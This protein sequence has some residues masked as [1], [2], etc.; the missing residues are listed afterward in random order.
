[1][2]T[3]RATVGLRARVTNIDRITMRPLL[4]SGLGLVV[5]H[6]TGVKV[7]YQGKS[8]A[9]LYA[10][11]RRIHLWRANEYNWV[12]LPGA[13]AD[14]WELV[15]FA[16]QHRAAHCKGFNDVG[17]GVLVL[18]GVDEEMTPG[19]TKG[20]RLMIDL[21][22]LGAVVP[23]PFIVGHGDIAATACP[24]NVRKAWAQVIE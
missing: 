2:I 17:H 9:D 24:G 16:G 6:Y 21:L 15:E 5:V 3:P 1:M 13:T 22:R 10:I 12:V 18:L 23:A 4:P 7:R 14:T 19:M 11:I 20:L 8:R